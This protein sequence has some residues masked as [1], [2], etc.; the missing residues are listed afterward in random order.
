M[1]WGLVGGLNQDHDF[2][3]EFGDACIAFGLFATA[4]LILFTMFLPKVIGVAHLKMSICVKNR[5]IMNGY[6]VCKEI[7]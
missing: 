6:D 2:A 3:Q 4:T 7:A 5:N 1:A